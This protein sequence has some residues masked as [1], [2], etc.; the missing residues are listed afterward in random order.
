VN[1]HAEERGDG[2]AGLAGNTGHPGRNG[3]APLVIDA[4][5]AT[6]LVL[7][8]E[9]SGRAQALVEAAIEANRRVIG[10]PLLTVEVANT[11]YAQRRNDEITGGE[12]DAA[13]AAYLRLGIETV[14]PGGLDRAAFAFARAHR[15]R[16]IHAAHYVVLAQML[17]TELWTGDRALLK[18]AAP[19]APWVCW[20]GDFSDGG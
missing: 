8:E 7:P 6:K 1:D 4:A 13:I 18:S 16:S 11:I 10:P 9:L 17:E 15:L 3:V 12:A 20:I 5:V 2:Q 14:S 19:V